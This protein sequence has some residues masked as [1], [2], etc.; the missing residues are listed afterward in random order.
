MTLEQTTRKLE[1]IKAT[2]RRVA[3]KELGEMLKIFE[4]CGYILPAQDI[5]FNA[6]M[7]HYDG[8]KK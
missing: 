1:E 2:E 7:K 6:V 5:C 4:Y 8:E 3:E